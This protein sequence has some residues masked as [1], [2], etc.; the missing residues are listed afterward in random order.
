MDSEALAYPFGADHGFDRTELRALLGGKG[1]GLVAMTA[2]GLPVPPGF[3]LT[4]AACR[5]F[6]TDGWSP[7]FDSA[8]ADGLSELEATAGKFL[9]STSTPLLVSVRSGAETSMPGMMDTVL[10]VGM[11]ASVEQALA[12]AAGSAAF[13]ADTHRR[14]LVGFA[15]LV[16]GAPQALTRS[17]AGAGPDGVPPAPTE[18]AAA[19]AEAGYP[20]PEDP[21]AQ[22]LAAVRAVFESWTGPRATRYREIEGIDASLG[23]AVTVQAMV[24]GNLGDRSG[25]GVAFSRNPTTGEAGL[26]GDFLVNAQGEDVVAGEAVTSSL[27]EMAARWPSLFAELDGVAATLEQHHR[28]MVDIEFTVEEGKLWLLQTRV[29]K[30]SPLAAFRVAIELAEDP[31]FDVDRA[32]AVERCRR[33]LDDPPT[34]AASQS[35]DGEST[36]GDG[37]EVVATG[38]AASPGLA[39]GVLCFDPDRAVELAE[40]GRDVILA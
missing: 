10:N 16:L 18:L 5:R 3:T 31:A 33:Y 21:R 24:F 17:A 7:A 4:T 28:D 22:V 38:L 12:A 25:T 39:S 23:T 20:V 34:V 15:E 9:G 26:V 8:I 1:A 19:L 13:A 14:A 32:E 6:L 40:A 11:N 29:G 36:A 30:R 37:T 2:A 35:T 27:A